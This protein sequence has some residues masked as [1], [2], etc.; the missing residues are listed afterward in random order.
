MRILRTSRR[1]DAT[2]D[3]CVEAY[4]R[5]GDMEMLGVL[6]ERYASMVFGVCLKYLRDPAESEDATMVIYELLTEKLKTH[7]IDSF[8][9]WLYVVAKNHCLQILRKRPLLLT[10]DLDNTRVQ[11]TN[12]LHP[13]D[14]ADDWKAEGLQT[15][16]ER[17]PQSQRQSIEL[18]YYH[19]MS[20]DQIA[21]EM[22]IDRNLVRSSIQN[23]RRNLRN[24][25]ERS[26]RERQPET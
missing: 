13:E 26:A 12:H 16:I 17:L 7:E 11:S 22:Q 15:C 2:D 18:F 25:M 6:F 24:C 9:G 21:D 14:I 1:T 4:R 10:E 20:Y 23:G 19:G 5:H 8:R 3:A